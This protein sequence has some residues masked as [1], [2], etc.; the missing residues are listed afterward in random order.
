MKN[1]ALVSLKVS[2]ALSRVSVDPYIFSVSK[3]HT[4]L[5]LVC[6]HY[7]QNNI[8]LRNF[9]WYESYDKTIF[10][11]LREKN[12]GANKTIQSEKD[13]AYMIFVANR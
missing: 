2:A 13:S 12:L 6:I 7:K 8:C 4:K 5:F 11:S 1:L 3:R 10:G 9:V